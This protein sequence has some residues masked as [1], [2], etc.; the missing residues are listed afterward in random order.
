MNDM[1]LMVLGL[2]L[3]A[4]GIVNM[5]GNISTIHSYNRRN[6]REEDVCRYGRWVGSGTLVIGLS[7]VAAYFL[8][9]AGQKQAGEWVMMIAVITGLALILYGQFKYNKGLF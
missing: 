5:T 8:Q 9:C 7:L 2:L 4:L 6:V 1:I 3:S